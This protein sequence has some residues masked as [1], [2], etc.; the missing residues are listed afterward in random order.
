[1]SHSLNEIETMSKRA[2]RGAG[3]PWGLAEEAGKTTRWLSAYGF[4]GV[5]LLVDL[6]EM[7]DALPILDVS[8]VSLEAETWSAPIG[9]MSPLIANASV[10][11]CAARLLSRGTITLE[12]VDLPL[13][14]VPS[15]GAVASTLGVSVVVEWQNARLVADGSAICVEGDP[16]ALEARHAAK[17]VFSIPAELKHRQEPMLRA[18]LS[19][20]SWSKLSAFAHRTYAPATEESRQLGAGSSRNDND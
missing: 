6:L 18:R 15:I 14:A 19:D 12:N 5:N 13:L 1:M 9:R 7:H 16:K 11:D 4:P 10:S 17:M 3:L 2:A 8:P 20:R